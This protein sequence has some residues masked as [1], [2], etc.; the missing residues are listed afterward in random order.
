[1]SLPPPGKLELDVKLSSALN[2]YAVT[3]QDISPPTAPAAAKKVKKSSSA[4]TEKTLAPAPAP[5]SAEPYDRWTVKDQKSIDYGVASTN[6]AKKTEGK[7]FYI[8][9]AINYA[10]GEWE[11]KQA[12][13]KSGRFTP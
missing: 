10:N 6:V 13:R 3:Q 12:I 8:T 7:P 9:T 2:A 4:A 5:A 11:S 1:M